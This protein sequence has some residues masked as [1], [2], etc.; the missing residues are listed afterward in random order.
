MSIVKP[1]DD[2][3]RLIKEKL[4]KQFALVVLSVTVVVIASLS[5]FLSL[6]FNVFLGALFGLTIGGIVGFY[7]I[8]HQKSKIR[9]NELQTD[10]ARLERESRDAQGQLDAFFKLLKTFINAD[11]EKIV[12][13]KI[14]ETS[15]Q[16]AKA[17]Y[18][19]LVP[20]DDRGQPVTTVRYGSLSEKVENAWVEYL[21]S[22]A[23][24]NTCGVCNNLGTMMDNCP[25]IQSGEFFISAHDKPIG[26]YC[27][28][29]R[30]G[31]R[32]LGL[33]NLY[34]TRDN[35]LDKVQKAN[36]QTLL[37]ESALVLESLRLR[38]RE[39]DDKKNLKTFQHF[40]SLED[41]LAELLDIARNMTG[42]DYV[43]LWFKDN[44][45]NYERK[46]I[47]SGDLPE[48]YLPYVETV[49]N[50]VFA[51]GQPFWDRD[52]RQTEKYQ[53]YCPSIIALPINPLEGEISGVMLVAHDHSSFPKGAQSYLI[54]FASQISLLIRLVRSAADIE[55]EAIMRERI[56][57]AREIHD[58][59]AQTLAFLKLQTLQM[60]N[61]L[62][63]GEINRLKDALA[64]SYKVVSEA[65]LDVRQAIDDLRIASEGEEFIDLMRQTLQE[66]EEIS[67]VEVVIQDSCSDIQLPG[68]LQAQVIRIVQEALSN[69]RKHAHAKRVVIDW[70]KCLDMLQLEIKDDG[71]GFSLDDIPR[72]SR[73]GLRGMQERAALIGA[74]LVINSQSNS[75]TSINL[76]IPF[77][78]GHRN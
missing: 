24:R 46:K 60:Q 5:T 2:L 22:P 33:L 59:L 72:S 12:I 44:H 23:V 49:L 28:P 43:L 25:L 41:L 14:L 26:V 76:N 40:S 78:L 67:G 38:K 42:S 71:I 35:Q 1:K 13:E 50:T 65:Y 39:T 61:M 27:L 70:R 16:L 37:D 77:T 55:I 69:V 19:S 47:S 9:I 57:L 51:T 21:A 20:L 34:F 53:G 15:I 62:S 68:E 63:S 48:I 6:E 31:D 29:L 3:N 73:Y 7:Y 30:R 52:D 58:G 54:N 45:P 74:D 36:L 17:D 32:D 10:L 75:G 4:S 18:A 56:R 66:F 11:D 64:Q 8:N